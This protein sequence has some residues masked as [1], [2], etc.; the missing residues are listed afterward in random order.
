MTVDTTVDPLID[1][2]SL[3]TQN[4]NGHQEMKADTNLFA[5][6][7]GLFG[8]VCC[9]P[10]PCIGIPF[11]CIACSQYSTD[12]E[13]DHSSQTLQIHSYKSFIRCSCLD[14]NTDIPYDQIQDVRVEA[15]PNSRVNGE[16][17]GIIEI[18]LTNGSTERITGGF[19]PLHTAREKAT[20][21][22]QLVQR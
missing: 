19:V 5:M 16:P 10:C 12:F 17:C 6:I 15:D 21:I 8:C 18:V 4:G 1:A 22:K 13:F 7:F 2:S 14:R 3:L 11:L 9:L 20:L